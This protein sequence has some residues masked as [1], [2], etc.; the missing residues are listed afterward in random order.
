MREGV[1]S[2]F[3]MFPKQFVG[4]MF[5]KQIIGDVSKISHD[6][7]SKNLFIRDFSKIFLIV[8]FPKHFVGKMF[9]NPIIGDVSKISHE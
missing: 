4:E 6:D 7:F 9:P 8:M 2:D 5:Q 3:V 1:E